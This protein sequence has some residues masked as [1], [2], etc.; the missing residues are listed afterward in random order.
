MIELPCPIEGCE[1]GTVS[2]TISANGDGDGNVPYGTRSWLEIEDMESDCAHKPAD[3]D[4]ETMDGIES[5]AFKAFEEP[6]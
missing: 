6:D 4:Q 5:A 2:I 1:H 3:Y